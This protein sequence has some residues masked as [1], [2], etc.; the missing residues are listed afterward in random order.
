[1]SRCFCGRELAPMLKWSPPG[2]YYWGLG[3]PIC[4]GSAT[5]ISPLFDT[6]VQ[7][8]RWRSDRPQFASGAVS[9]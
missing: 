9:V 4:C 7:A 6:A 3:C 8:L 1:V 5:P 2:N